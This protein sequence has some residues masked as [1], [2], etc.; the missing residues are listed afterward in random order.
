MTLSAKSLPLIACSFLTLGL[1]QSPANAASYECMNSEDMNPA[2]QVV[3]DND[4]LGALDER[5]DSWYRRAMVRAGYFDQTNS[6]RNAQRQ[7]LVRRNACG[8][9]VFCLKRRYLSR[10]RNL[11][12]YV[13]HV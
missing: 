12:N 8:A 10:I 7:W 13:E 11:K 1:T 2:E 9:N 4:M 6:V 3:C 5:L